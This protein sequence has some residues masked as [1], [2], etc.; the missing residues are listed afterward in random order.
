LAR[1]S[2]GAAGYTRGRQQQQLRN[3]APSSAA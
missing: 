1:L 2:S 3:Q